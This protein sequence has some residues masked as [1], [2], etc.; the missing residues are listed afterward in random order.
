MRLL[1]G[2][3][4]GY[5]ITS[6]AFT[7]DGRSLASCASGH[8]GEIRLWDLATGSS[9][10]VSEGGYLTWAALAPDGRLLAWG[11]TTGVSLYHIATGERRKLGSGLG[12]DVSFSPDG[13]LLASTNGPRVWDLATGEVLPAWLTARG[14][15]YRLTFAPDGRT[16]AF[17]PW[18]GEPGRTVRHAIRLADTATAAEQMALTG[19]GEVASELAFTPDGRRLA[20][21]CGQFLM[22]WDVA[23]GEV[24]WRHKVDRRHFQAL[25]FT[26]DGRLLAA[27][28]NDRTVRFWDTRTWSQAAAYDWDAGPLVS[29]AIARDGMRAAAG[30]RRGLIVV[31]DL[32]D[33]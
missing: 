14:G 27:T 22:V 11:L 6:L 13:R 19:H 18:T 25:A 26:P 7:P 3:R 20:A 32:D 15:A 28:R 21:A 31:W 24:V 10:V 5:P 8:R 29:V 9:K 17:A 12:G 2:H 23:S 4:P 33:L 1:K 30:S 16:L